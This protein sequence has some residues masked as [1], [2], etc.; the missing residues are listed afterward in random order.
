MMTPDQIATVR[1]ARGDTPR[2]EFAALLGCHPSAI[3]HIEAGRATYPGVL[4]AYYLHG[5]L[6]AEQVLGIREIPHVRLMAERLA[7]TTSPAA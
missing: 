5:R 3:S 1:A 2:A 6:T 4:T 7:P